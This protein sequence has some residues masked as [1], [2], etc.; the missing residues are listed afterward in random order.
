MGVDGSINIDSS[1]DGTG[2]SKGLDKLSSVAKTSLGVLTGVIGGAATALGGM[3]T[4]AVKTG[5]DFESEMSRVAAISGATGA[6]FDA[7]NKQAIQLGADTKFSAT[8]AAEGMENLASAGFNA[9]QIAAAMPGMLNLAASSGEDLATS[10]DI[11]AS[12]LNGFGLSA[13]QAGHVADVLAK[14]AAQT[15]A[16]VGDTG[17]AL[18]YIAPQAHAAGWSIESVTAAIGEMANSG[19]KGS[20]AGTTLRGALQNL[21]APS[22]QQADAMQAIGFSAYDAQGHMKSLSQIVSDLQKDTAGLTEQQRNQYLSTIFGADAMSGMTVLMNQGSGALD[23]MTQSLINSNGSAQDMAN[24]M[25]DNLKGAAQNLTGSLES[26]GISFYQSIDNPLKDVVNKAN[27][28]IQ[29]LMQAFQSGGITGLVSKLGSVLSDAVSQIAA[30]APQMINLAVLLIQSFVNGIAANAPELA[31]SAVQIVGAL[32]QGIITLLPSIGNAAF[33][34]VTAIGNEL[35]NDGP[36]MSA[37]ATHLITTIVNGLVAGLPQI[38]NMAVQLIVALAQGLASHAPQIISG[39][40]QI[41]TTLVS[42]L[43]QAAPQLAAAAVQLMAGF[44]GALMQQNPPAGIFLGVIGAVKGLQGAFSGLDAAAKAAKSLQDVGSIADKI[45]AP[46]KNA[47]DNIKTIAGVAADAAGHVKDFAGGVASV[48]QSVAGGVVSGIKGLAGGIASVAQGAAGLATSLAESAAGFIKMGAQAVASAAQLAIQKGASL[49]VAAAEK[50]QAAA[51]WLLNTAMEANP[52]GLAI[53]AIAALIAIIILLWTRCEGFRNVVMTVANAIAGFFVAAWGVIQAIWGGVVAFFQ[54]VWNGIVFIFSVAGSWFGGVFGTA[55][56]G[57]QSAWA[58]VTGFF[59]GIWNGIVFVF[60]VVAGWFGAVFGNAVGTIQSAWSGVTGFF[61]GI[62]SGISGAFASVGG[63]FRDRFNDAVSGIKSVWSGV[64][65]F[66]SGIKD[67]IAGAF[68]GIGD[69]IKDAFM[70]GLTF[71][72]NLPG[73]ALKWGG[74]IIN[75]IVNGIKNAAS[76]VGD[77]IKGV[78]QDIRNFLHFST[79]DKGPLADFDTYMPDMM[80]LMA[81]GIGKNKGTVTGALNGL[82]SDMQAQ[83]DAMTAKMQ[84]SVTAQQTATWQY[85]QAAPSN[86]T[87]VVQ[88]APVAIGDREIARAANGGNYSSSGSRR[89]F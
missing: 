39:A 21:Q 86:V 65:G 69:H 44:F 16:A 64:T 6:D 30:Q 67:G 24:T 75:G 80:A 9:Q 77:A 55:V 7:L 72:Q 48:A 89:Y 74:D 88:P 61:S 56:A 38:I 82:T 85:T 41:I 31:R 8:Q 14:N 87:V 15:N 1:I 34:L 66:F 33:Q 36:Q 53:I 25:N 5:M 63:W 4:A 50:I 27:G 12:A 18:K 49:A 57:I 28:Y 59:S 26:L 10:S 81:Q 62:W 32:A 84:A 29:Q 22:K 3:A 2:F 42:A 51:Q 83:M 78:A 35:L 71:I 54:G 70:S 52:I 58:G 60:S 37:G 47:G 11:A 13:D 45:T 40:Q 20:Q 79:P 73:E 68:S 76:A 46:F 23:N 17:E 43:L 19:I